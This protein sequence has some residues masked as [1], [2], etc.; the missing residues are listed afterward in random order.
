MLSTKQLQEQLEK[1]IASVSNLNSL[2]ELKRKYLGDK[3]V[4]KQIFK[5]FSKLSAEEK[6]EYGKVINQ[7]KQKLLEFI[8]N[9]KQDLLES[10]IRAEEEK[11]DIDLTAPFNVNS[12]SRPQRYKT[13]GNKHPVTLEIERFLDVFKRMGF[14]V[15][16]GRQLD[17][18]YYNFEALAIPKD[19]PAREMWDTFYTEERYIP[20]V[21]TSN[22]QVRIMRMYKKPPIRTVIFG[23]CF[24]NE[25]V[26]ATHSHTFYQI[27]GLYIDKHINVSNMLFTL[28]SYIEGFFEQKITW[29]IQP[30]HFPF[31]EPGLELIIRCVFCNGKGC[32][33]CKNTGWI[34]AAGAGMI[35]PD[36]LRAGGIDPAKYSGFAWGLGVERLVM[37]KNNI[38]DIRLLYLNDIRL[39][40]AK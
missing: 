14:D 24:R 17:N 29:R 23:K 34:E 5:E 12:S 36:V 27:E 19:H 37:N 21:H 10:S 8:D 40:K 22:M 32:S 7:L 3:G 31:V 39:L 9:K 6:K 38:N 1:D 25:E 28:K 16:E 20:A 30:A 26:D 15:V 11:Q 2:Q 4:F 35:H 18:D 33:V 13:S